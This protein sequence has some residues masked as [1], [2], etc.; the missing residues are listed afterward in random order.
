MRKLLASAVI[1]TT[2]FGGM[3]VAQ[4]QKPTQPGRDHGLCTAF[5]NGQ[6]KGHDKNGEPGPFADLL[7]AHDGDSDAAALQDL[8]NYCTTVGIGGQPGQNGRYTD[9]FDDGDCSNGSA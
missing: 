9:C 5:F 2:M 7:A 3:A 4:A 1:A 8:Y 6:K